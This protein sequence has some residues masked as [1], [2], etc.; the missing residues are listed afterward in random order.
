MT[1]WEAAALGA[2]RAV[3]RRAAAVW[4]ADR[5]DA[6]ERSKDLSDLVALRVGDR[7]LRR[8]LERQI[9]D[10]ADQVAQRLEPLCQHEFR[11]LAEGDRAA[12]LIAV[13]D[14]FA[15]AD[16]SDEALFAADMDAV[17]LAGRLRAGL[18]RVGAAVG[19]GEPA[20]RFLDLVLDE[21][22]DCFIRIVTQLDAFGPRASVE[23]L[24]RLSRLGEQVAVV[25]AR[26][27]ARRVEVAAGTEQD[28]DF[29][30]RYLGH[31]GDRLDEL[32]LFGVDVRRYRPRTTLSV[33]YISLTVTSAAGSPDDVRRSARPASVESAG[34]RAH[35][36][37]WESGAVRVETALAAG[38]RVLVRGE[39]GSGKTTLLAWLAVTAARGRFTGPQRT[40][41]G[42]VPFLVKL[43]SHAEGRLPPPE[44]FLDGV[45]DPI[46]GLMPA[47]WAH[48]LLD[49]GR[50][51]L[52]VDGVD[53]LPAARRRAIRDW[54]AGLVTAYPKARILVTSRPAAAAADWL[55]EDGF[56]TVMLEPM[57]P[58]DVR[59]LIRHWHEAVRDAG[60][61]PCDAS[62]LPGYEAR[63]LA[64]LAAAA[65]LRALAASPL[66]CAMLCALNLDR[67]T[68]LPADRMSL[69]AA[70]VNLLLERRDAERGIP[71]A[72][73]SLSIRDKIYLLQDL[74]WCL[75]L[76][77]RSERPRAA[78]VN[79]IARKL[80][81]MPHV[82]A[83]PENV[84]RH[85]LV[86]SGV[87]REPV[88]GRVDFVHRTIQEYLTAKEIAE[89]GHIEMLLERAHLDQ[90]RYVVIMTAGHANTPQR[91]ELLI[92]LLDR[93]DR[94]SQH[95]R[96]FGLLAAA[97]LEAARTLPPELLDRV[98]QHSAGFRQT[99]PT[100]QMPP[101]RPPYAPRPSLTA[102]TRSPSSL[103]TPATPAAEFSRNSRV[104]G[105]TSTPTTTPAQSSST[106][107]STTEHCRSTSPRCYPPCT[108]SATS[109]A[110]ASTWQGPRTCPAYET[111]PP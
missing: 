103:D 92:G 72:D 52:L 91:T 71:A 23:M 27:P 37:R 76:N 36:R 83:D 88:P 85:L 109:T 87:I 68:N 70:A 67:R 29:G 21:C 33:A 77:N 4:L 66:L 89:A 74:A 61:P 12:A 102:P 49:A 96:Q 100:W 80:R 81:T 26:L 97:C 84:L 73:V 104:P 24:D 31:V 38:Q 1:G 8:R 108:T 14:T 69:Y 34:W 25:L 3:A 107:H 32:E 63:L 110:S 19:L 86:R 64:A 78:A 101:R 43:R 18:P 39:A 9:D 53:E 65:H 20:S 58:A 28:Y 82:T 17:K 10:V 51:L 55:I 11:G 111:C 30:R 41:N 54:L 48:R 15:A 60:N 59:A 79:D 46:V 98:H 93:A 7:F 56:A 2:G 42:C 75:S 6:A 95:A 35:D 45:A 99:S 106:P 13:V 50:V 90:W 16:L 62:E 47:G 5:R 44:S 94:L 105:S 22:C 40:W 57:G